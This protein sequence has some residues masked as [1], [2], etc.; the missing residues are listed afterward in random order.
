MNPDERP[1]LHYALVLFTSVYVLFHFVLLPYLTAGETTYWYNYFTEGFTSSG[2][3]PEN[4]SSRALWVPLLNHFELQM[5]PLRLIYAF[6]A[7]LF[8]FVVYWKP[9]PHI[10]ASYRERLIFCL[11]LCTIP[12]FIQYRGLSFGFIQLLNIILTL[13]FLESLTGIIR[14]PTNR[15][16]ALVLLS[17]ALTCV[18]GILVS[19]ILLS[20]SVIMLK[21]KKEYAI[22]LLLL[23][24]AMCFLFAILKYLLNFEF[25]PSPGGH[26]SLWNPA[27]SITMLTRFLGLYLLPGSVTAILLLRK[28]YSHDQPLV[29]I[30]TRLWL[31]AAVLLLLFP[32]AVQGSIGLFAILNTIIL[33]QGLKE[34]FEWKMIDK[35]VPRLITALL[36][37]L[38]FLALPFKAAIN[39]RTSTLNPVAAEILDTKSILYSAP[40]KSSQ[41][42]FR[43]YGHMYDTTS[44][45][46]LSMATQYAGIPVDNHA[47]VGN[48]MIFLAHRKSI[49]ALPHV[50][51]K[52]V[53]QLVLF[54][55]EAQR[56][57]RIKCANTTGEAREL[58]KRKILE[59][60][61]DD[62]WMKSILEKAKNT[63]TAVSNQLKQDALWS[64][65]ADSTIS[66]DQYKV[67]MK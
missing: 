29:F 42:G 25:N 57:D 48:D 58:M 67:L 49:E 52:S 60:Q 26:T 6:A 44:T 33:V 15:W 54:K 19:L 38:T 35:S 36:L 16:L 31:T 8:L 61:S 34:L 30:A 53:G 56:A 23:G 3:N 40:L 5:Q 22:P 1:G 66:D 10:H 21:R 37:L 11:I 59:I 2:F 55:R 18:N 39:T 12:V 43:V 28:P 46:L 62:N 51:I 45:I 27:L 4:S 17:I 65:R 47:L 41:S 9:A 50:V 64:L 32:S 7:W 63:G 13:G 20:L 24:G 14:N